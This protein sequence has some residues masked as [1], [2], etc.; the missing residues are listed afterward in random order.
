MCSANAHA[1]QLSEKGAG[2]VT[3]ITM[4]NSL[5]E[6]TMIWVFGYGSLT[7]KA[8]FPYRERVVGHVK[9]FA[10]RFWQGSTDHRGTPGA[11]RPRISP[12]INS[13]F[14]ILSARPSGDFG[15]STRGNGVM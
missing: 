1:Q 4:Q 9:G 3:D 12:R 7:W 2:R 15:G 6:D 8:D 10:R 11:V 13:I 14:R 5:G